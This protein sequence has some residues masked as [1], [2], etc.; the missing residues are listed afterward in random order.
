M[1]KKCKE[2]AK[3]LAAILPVDDPDRLRQWA[4]EQRSTKITR[5]V[6]AY[7]TLTQP[8][9]EQKLNTERLP[10]KILGD[11]RQ[12]KGAESE[13]DT[14][15]DHVINRMSNNEL[16]RSFLEW[17]GFGS[18]DYKIKNAIEKIFEVELE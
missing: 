18:Y 1:C 4:V 13:N 8:S 6:A 3:V 14:S 15:V 5:M 16:L 17:N 7:L 11:I 2:A 9:D 10:P 12:N